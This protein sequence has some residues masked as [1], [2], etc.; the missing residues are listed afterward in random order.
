MPAREINAEKLAQDLNDRL[1]KDNSG[2][3]VAKRAS[4]AFLEQVLTLPH[5]DQYKAF[6]TAQ[7]INDSAR[8][9]NA[10]IPG[11]NIV[12][13]DLDGDGKRQE[14]Y[15]FSLNY[16]HRYRDPWNYSESVESVDLYIAAPSSSDKTKKAK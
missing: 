15:K 16:R 9:K 11:L 13:A 2:V 4:E 6:K 8:N 5:D 12:F 1:S 10:Y 14:L 7:D 3:I